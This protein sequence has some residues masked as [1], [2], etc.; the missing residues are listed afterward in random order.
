MVQ[1]CKDMCPRRSH[2]LYPLTEV[3]IG[4]KGR[5]IL[6]NDALEEYFKELKCVVSVER[7]LNYPYQ[8]VAFTVHTYDSYNQLSDV[9]SHNNRPIDFSQGD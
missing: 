2:V 5:K 1:C 9:I 4:P 8:T 6:Q 7:F 3:A